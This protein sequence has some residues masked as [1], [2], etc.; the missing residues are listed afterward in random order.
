M[1]PVRSVIVLGG[2]TAGLLAAIALKTKVPGL[3][4]RVIRSKEMG[5]IGVGEGTTVAV[6]GYLHGFLKLNPKVFY[7]EVKPIWKLGIKYLWGPRES[8]NFTFARHMTDEV[9]LPRPLGYYCDDQIDCGSIEFCDD[10]A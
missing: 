9:T 6:T 7:R 1:E 2:G 4:V 8:F 10:V 5:V 3:G